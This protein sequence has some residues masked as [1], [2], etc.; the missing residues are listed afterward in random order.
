MVATTIAYVI[1]DEPGVWTPETTVGARRGSC[2][3]SAALLVALMR[4][5][6]IAAV[7]VREAHGWN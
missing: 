6:G 7:A 5:R 1:R 4:A 3:D 2:R